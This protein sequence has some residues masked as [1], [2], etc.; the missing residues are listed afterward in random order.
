M[1]FKSIFLILFS[2]VITSGCQ[3]TGIQTK[4]LSSLEL[5]EINGIKSYQKGEY[6]KSFELLKTPATWGY[7]GAQYTI[8]FMFLKGHHVEQSTLMGMGWLGVATEMETEDW[9]EQYRN[10]YSSATSEQQ[11]KIDGIVK[12]YIKRYGMKSQ[13]ITC[14]KSSTVLSR[15]IQHSCH[16]SERISTVYEVDL[17]E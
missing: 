3:S 7:K 10:F 4:H 6:E 11:L 15:R 12:E 14:T 5:D 9:S 2:L 13:N 1:S 17:V 8:A 16:R